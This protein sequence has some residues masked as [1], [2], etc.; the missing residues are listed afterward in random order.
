MTMTTIMQQAKEKDDEI[1]LEHDKAMENWSGDIGDFE[2]V[3]T[4]VEVNHKVAASRV[5][6]RAIIAC[7]TVV[8]LLVKA[9]I[10]P[11]TQRTT[12]NSAKIHFNDLRID[13]MN[14]DLQEVKQNIGRSHIISS[15]EKK[16]RALE[17]RASEERRSITCEKAERS[18]QI[19]NI[20]AEFAKK[21]IHE[22]TGNGKKIMWKLLRKYA[23]IYGSNKSYDSLNSGTIPSIAPHMKTC[24][25]VPTFNTKNEKWLCFDEFRQNTR[26]S[27]LY[28]KQHYPDIVM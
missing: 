10:A 18:F 26:T 3:K 7:G 8:P 9:A 20:D 1:A 21:A 27:S 17:I 2:K 4:L 14:A 25:F 22:L 23:P 5:H 11:F 13:K 6:Q 12:V 15:D 19:H 24:M 28:T 16:D